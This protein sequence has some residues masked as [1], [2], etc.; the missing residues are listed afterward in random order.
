M[1]QDRRSFLKNSGLG[2]SVLALGPLLAGAEAEAAATQ[3]G[4]FDFNTPFNRLGTDSVHWDEPMRD[5]KMSK[6]VAGMGVADMD[7]RC[8]PAIMAGLAKRMRHEN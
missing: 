3:S 8:A 2:T 7:F 5:E 1:P 6:I 4:A